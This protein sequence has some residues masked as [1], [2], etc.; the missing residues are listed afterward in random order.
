MGQTLKLFSKEMLYVDNNGETN[1]RRHV[2]G[3]PRR[4]YQTLPFARGKIPVKRTKSLANGTFVREKTRGRWPGK[5]AHRKTLC[6][7]LA[8]K[9]GAEP[10]AKRH[11]FSLAEPLACS[12]TF[13]CS[14][15]A[16][17]TTT[18]LCGGSD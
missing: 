12:L 14:F 3:C 5:S 13:V 8:E 17:L 7:P 2:D 9:R 4:I 6:Q 15:P 11:A 16:P 18:D 10:L 1:L